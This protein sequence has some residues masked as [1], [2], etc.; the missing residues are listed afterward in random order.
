ME[1]I[2]AELTART[3]EIALKNSASWVYSQIEMLKSKREN[4]RTIAEL[5]Q[6]IHNLISDKND[7]MGIIQTY[8]QQFV[9]QQLSQEDI[10]YISQNV[11]PLLENLSVGTTEEAEK[12]KENIETMKPLVS[13]KTLNIMQ[14]IGFNFKK[15]IGMPLTSLTSELIRS[16]NSDENRLSDDTRKALA[17]RDAEL[18]KV[19]ND[20]E[21]YERLKAMQE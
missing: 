8:E 21:A 11:I 2:I 16:M 20:K 17:V 4:N 6:I 14:L 3:A 12:M 19:I 9:A 10:N 1:S 5:E 15:G 18:Y 13:D 7:L